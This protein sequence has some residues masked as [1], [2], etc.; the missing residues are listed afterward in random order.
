[1]DTMQGVAA[2]KGMINH[3]VSSMLASNYAH[4]LSVSFVL[5]EGVL[6]AIMYQARDVEDSVVGNY[7]TRT[8]LYSMKFTGFVLSRPMRYTET[9]SRSRR[10]LNRL[11]VPLDLF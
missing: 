4:I 1:M 3:G 2:T 7:V 11:C 8:V 10:P 5:S 9:R 6:T